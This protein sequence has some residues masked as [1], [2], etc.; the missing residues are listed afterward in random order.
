MKKLFCVS[1]AMA[2]F[3]SLSA[4]AAPLVPNAGVAG[5]AVSSSEAD[6]ALV[7]IRSHSHKN[8]KKVHKAQGQGRP[9]T[10]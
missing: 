7:Q 3:G 4:Q 6:G 8:M 9:K 10:Q 1:L 5:A 2:F